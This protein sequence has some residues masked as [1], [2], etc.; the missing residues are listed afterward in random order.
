MKRSVFVPLAGF[1]LAAGFWYGLQQPTS[2][3]KVVFFDVGQGD[4][5]A[6]TWGDEALIIDTGPSEARSWRRLLKRYGVRSVRGIFL[7][8]P[9]RD[10][11][12]GTG[13]LRR[14]FPN[15]PVYIRSE[16][17]V[18]GDMVASLREWGIPLHEVRWIGAEGMREW[19][20]WRLRFWLPQAPDS[21]PDNERSLVISATL[22][23]RSVWM[24]GDL[25]MSGEMNLL[26]R[27]PSPAPAQIVKA[28]HHGSAAS[29]ST[30]WLDAFR[31]EFVVFSCGRDNPY[32]HPHPA[33][34]GR[35]EDAG[36]TIRRTDQDGTVWFEWD[37]DKFRPR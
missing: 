9:D 27:I 24:T 19:G 37:G 16:F 17:R 29:L 2:S 20:P 30:A 31:P 5:T 22:R 3:A 18:H 10:H 15:A 33:A 21:S 8:H 11:I 13:T 23:E 14:D 26:A 25:G 35:A 1:A 7:T 6:L 4:C 34:I 12:T 32:R 28:G 36:A